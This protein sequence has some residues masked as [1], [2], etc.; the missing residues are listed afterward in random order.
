LEV[1]EVI[2][3]SESELEAGVNLEG[4]GVTKEMV[5]WRRECFEEGMAVEFLLLVFCLSFVGWA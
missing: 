5:R 2:E 1:I 4:R 3:R